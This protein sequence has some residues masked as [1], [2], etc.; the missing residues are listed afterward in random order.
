MKASANV[1]NQQMLE[2]E[3]IFPNNRYPEKYNVAGTLQPINVNFSTKNGKNFH[4]FTP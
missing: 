3:F 4:T 1:M 2:S